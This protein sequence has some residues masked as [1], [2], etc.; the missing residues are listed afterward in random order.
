V[1]CVTIKNEVRL[2]IYSLFSMVVLP[3][4]TANV[5]A[6]TLQDWLYSIDDY[7]PTVKAAWSRW[8]AAKAMTPQA[9]GGYPDPVI[10][11]D[12]ERN[13]TSLNDYMDL[14]YMLEQEIPWP[15]RLGVDREVARLE[16]EAVGFE[17]LEIRRK[18]KAKIISATWSLWKV[19]KSLDSLR[20]NLELTE[21]LESIT[22]AGLEAGMSSQTDFLRVQ[23]EKV[24]V[25]NEIRSM[26][27][28]EQSML[29]MLNGLLN[30]PPKTER[31]TEDMP[32][33]PV[34]PDSVAKLQEDARLYC[35]IL[36]ASV[37]REFAKDRA[38]ESARLE[39]RPNFSVRVEARQF[40]E[41]GSID[42]VDTGIFMNIPWLW[43]GKYKGRRAEAEADRMMAKAMLDDEVAMT[44][45]E[46]QK[47]YSE[48]ESRQRTMNLY[49]HTI[50]PRTRDLAET[51]RESYQSGKMSAMEML[52]AQRMVQD[53]LMTWYEETAAYASA[54]AELASIVQ[55][56]TPDEFET[57]LPLH[58]KE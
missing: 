24:K 4:G 32:E 12:V 40:D 21:Q 17:Y 28:E 47:I 39:S 27:Q 25:E 44:L 37:W 43:G 8:Q 42:E 33:L 13:N 3:A 35:C 15:G 18:S 22:R 29:A 5:H 41:S 45:A 58:N 52:D 9:G 50:L 11:V 14:E 19:R 46:I 2:L 34:L 48:A 54:H 51:S 16:A 56:W 23:V 31:S 53:A 7:N 55:P 20:E 1:K 6:N 30:Q 26:E 10:G 49:K 36:M 38:R 57:G